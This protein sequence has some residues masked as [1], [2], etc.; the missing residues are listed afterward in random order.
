MPPRYSPATMTSTARTTAMSM[1]FQRSVPWTPKPHPTIASNLTTIRTFRTTPI[2]SSR[3][4]ALYVAPNRRRDDRQEKREAILA[5]RILKRQTKRL[6]NRI[7]P[8]QVHQMRLRAKER[9]LVAH[10]ASTSLNPPYHA[11]HPPPTTLENPRPAPVVPYDLMATLE[12]LKSH[13]KEQGT[14]DADTTASTRSSKSIRSMRTDALEDTT[15]TT[16]PNTFLTIPA[17]DHESFITPS[18]PLPVP[19]FLRSKKPT[20]PYP[21]VPTTSQGPAFGFGLTDSDAKFLFGEATK[22]VKEMSNGTKTTED[23][24]EQAEM[25]RRLTALENSGMKGLHKWNRARMVEVFGRRPFDTGSPEPRFFTVKIEAMK[26]HL[27]KFV[28]DK[29]TKRQLQQILSKRTAMLKYLR[30]KDLSRFVES[31]HA[32]G[33]D[34]DS[35]RV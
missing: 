15:K 9:T 1:L 11:G 4:P 30:R 20:A 2:S 16:G 12:A 8:N 3:F 19:A 6:E 18:Q 25:V 10:H 7:I 33:I 35:I 17:S 13:Q 27:A 32:L 14:T 23:V 22:A 26:A 24:G 29:S 28:K 31:C 5:N 34:P 21:K